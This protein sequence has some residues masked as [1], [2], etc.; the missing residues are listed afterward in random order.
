M[1]QAVLRAKIAND[2]SLPRSARLPCETEWLRPDRLK[3]AGKILDVGAARLE[4]RRALEKYDARPNRIGNLQCL[5]PGL[6]DLVR[7][8][9]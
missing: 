8:L 7:I 5:H 4:R 6:P 2:F 9:K 3:E 1:N